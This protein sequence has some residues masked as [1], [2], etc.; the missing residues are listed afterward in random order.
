MSLQG[1][2]TRARL[3]SL[4]WAPP[5]DDDASPVPR[6]HRACRRGGPRKARTRVALQRAEDGGVPSFLT[7]T[8]LCGRSAATAPS[9][10]TGQVGGPRGAGSQMTRRPKL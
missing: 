9:R 7:V 2:Q 1:F 3:A 5:K 10:A 8:A 4:A 6:V